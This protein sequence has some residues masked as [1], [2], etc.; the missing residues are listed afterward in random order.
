VATLG[1]G[2]RVELA[3]DP[4]LRSGQPFEEIAGRPGAVPAATPAG[5]PATTVDLPV[6][7]GVRARVTGVQSVV[8]A[9]TSGLSVPGPEIVDGVL[10]YLGEELLDS[11]CAS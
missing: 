7:P 9:E 10:L 4:P 2:P 5:F 8:V 1:F 6:A 3:A 11:L